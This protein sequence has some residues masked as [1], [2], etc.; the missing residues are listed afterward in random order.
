MPAPNRCHRWLVGLGF[1]LILGNPSAPVAWLLLGLSL[2][3][4]I[5]LAAKAHGRQVRL[6]REAKGVFAV[7][8]RGMNPPEVEAIWKRDR[9]IFWPTMTV[10]SV[11]LVG[12]GV[13]LDDLELMVA[14]VPMAFAASFVVAG[15]A[16]WARLGGSDWKS[17]GWWTLAYAAAVLTAWSLNA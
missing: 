14:G 16:S 13:W 6:E 9:R 12:V 11:A 3:A 17:F 8:F 2:V 4:W 1:D 7:D 15:T 10:L 5:L